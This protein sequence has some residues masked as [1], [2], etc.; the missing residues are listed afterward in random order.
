MPPLHI[1]LL[2]A[3]GIARAHLPGWL[4]L[5]A[6][7]GVHTQDGSADKLA[8]EYAE[9]GHDVTAVPDL[10]ELL[11]RCR[12][13]DICTPTP[14][15]KALALAAVARGRHVVCEKP[16]ALTVPDAEEIATAAAAAGVHLHPAHVVRYFPAYAAMRDAVVRGDL[17]D[18]AVLRFT[19]GGARPQWAPWFGDPDQSG[20]VIMD[21]MVH[22]IDIARWVAGEVVRVHARTR[23]SERATG[24]P[25]DVVTAT[26][27]LTH[28]SGAVSH[29]TGLWGLPDQPFRTT[30]RV[31]GTDGLLRHDS[32]AVPGFR[33]TAQG[34]RAAGEG[35]PSSPMTESPYLAELREFAASWDDPAV[36]PRVDAHDGLAAVRIARAAV[37]S[38][39]TGDAVELAPAARPAPQGPGAATTT[40]PTEPEEPTR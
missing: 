7:V 25:A 13:V 2:G 35:I 24:A 23:G 26:A 28:A 39:R 11:S 34:V 6:R 4:E 21:L 40:R 17:G 22:D 5:G 19:R 12:A 16:L 31:A 9:L 38:S 18:L 8:G 37:E 14:T 32:A 10:D 36:R 33:I 20:G 1:G 29:V 27:V 30:F 3:G 15:H